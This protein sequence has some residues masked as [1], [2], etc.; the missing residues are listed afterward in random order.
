LE[1]QK[2]IISK[3]LIKEQKNPSFFS[4]FD[5]FCFKEIIY[6]RTK[7]KF[8]NLATR[9]VEN[10][11]SLEAQLKYYCNLEKLKMHILNDEQIEM[12]NNIPNFKLEKHLNDM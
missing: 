11:L 12:L 4:F 8:F 9:I 2:N 7:R 1:F 5:L 6:S 10:K 3:K